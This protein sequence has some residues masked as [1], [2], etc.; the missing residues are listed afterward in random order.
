MSSP[1]RFTTHHMVKRF[2][3]AIESS[4]DRSLIKAVLNL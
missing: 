3:F 4:D 2:G 1:N